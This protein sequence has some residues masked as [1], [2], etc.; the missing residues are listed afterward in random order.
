MSPVECAVRPHTVRQW[1][2]AYDSYLVFGAFEG[3]FFC[4]G[5][6]GFFLEIGLLALP[7]P[8]AFLSSF[9]CFLYPCMPKL[10][11]LADLPLRRMD[12]LG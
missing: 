7:P 12:V 9:F 8:D 2:S 3:R 4:R 5:G 6:G 1:S 10:D 11:T